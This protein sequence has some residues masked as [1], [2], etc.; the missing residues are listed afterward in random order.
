LLPEAAGLE[1]IA[2][3]AAVVGVS[4]Q[5]QDF[6]FQVQLHTR[7]LLVLVVP[8]VLVLAQQIQERKEIHQYLVL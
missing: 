8:E 6:P 5:E 1:P 3:E 2:A 7:S 4:E